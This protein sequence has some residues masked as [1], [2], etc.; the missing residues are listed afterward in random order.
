[1][2]GLMGRVA[3]EAGMSE[4]LKRM[5][6]QAGLKRILLVTDA[7]LVLGRINPDNFLGGENG[8]D[9]NFRLSAIAPSSSL[10]AGSAAPPRRPPTARVPRV[11]AGVE[12]F[13]DLEYSRP[14]DRPLL[15]DLYVPADGPGPRPVVLSGAV[16]L[17]LGL[18]LLA[19]SYAFQSTRSPGEAML[20]TGIALVSTTP[21]KRTATAAAT[22]TTRVRLT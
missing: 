12:A 5:L 2:D 19:M 3:D 21:I 9:D 1:M 15:L 4:H 20:W 17:G 7:N 13:R 16:L 10:D 14:D 6:K 22:T 8:G 18:A 11:P